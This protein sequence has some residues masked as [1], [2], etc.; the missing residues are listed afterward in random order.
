M[1]CMAG[2]TGGA[3]LRLPGGGGGGAEEL[4]FMPA[5]LALLGRVR[6][7]SDGLCIRGISGGDDRLL[8]KS[9]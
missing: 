2:G 5:W 9:S 3:L 8:S 1:L 6:S 4:C 7:G